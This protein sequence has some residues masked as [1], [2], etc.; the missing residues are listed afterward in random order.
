MAKGDL[1]PVA[2]TVGRPTT[3]FRRVLKCSL[4]RLRF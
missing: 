4:N 1:L 2:A 3:I